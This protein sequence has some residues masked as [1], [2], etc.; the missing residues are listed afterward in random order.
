MIRGEIDE[1]LSENRENAFEG[2]SAKR[3]Y[4]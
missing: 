4:G 1:V 2:S 3:V